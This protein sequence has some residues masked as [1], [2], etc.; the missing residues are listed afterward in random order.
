MHR[1]YL[2]YLWKL[3]TYTAY[4]HQICIT[5]AS[6]VD[7]PIDRLISGLTYFSKSQ[8]SKCKNHIFDQRRWHKS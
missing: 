2:H 3:L 1:K 8:G 6:D 5:G 4:G 7:T